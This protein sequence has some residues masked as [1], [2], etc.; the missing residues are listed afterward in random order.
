MSSTSD[1]KLRERVKELKCLYAV[2][3]FA[4]EAD[5]DVDALLH[6][7]A[8][9]LPDAMQFPELAEVSITT[10]KLNHETAGF[11]KCR[12]HISS[13]LE[14]KGKGPRMI[15]TIRVGYRAVEKKQ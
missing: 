5:N 8:R 13:H 9:L 3:R 6:E 10:S 11:A 1:L 14:A 12:T 4:L 15:G 2:T 7:T